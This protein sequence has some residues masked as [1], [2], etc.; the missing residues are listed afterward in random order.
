MKRIKISVI[1]SIYNKG[2]FLKEALDSLIGQTFKDF[3]IICVNDASEDAYTNAILKEYQKREER[4]TAIWLTENVGPGKAKNIGFEQARGEYI[5]FL[6]ADDIFHSNMLGEMYKEITAN[7]ADV[8]FCGLEWFYM[9]D[10]TKMYTVKHYPYVYA[11]HRNEEDAASKIY[12]STCDKLCRRT[13]LKENQICFQELPSQDDLLYS[14]MVCFKTIKQCKC[15]ELFIKY[16]TQIS[17]QISANENLMNFFKAMEEVLCR[18]G[19][20]K[21]LKK[22]VV[23]TIIIWGT[24]T[25]SREKEKK[26]KNNYYIFIQEIL[27]KNKE[28]SFECKIYNF[29]FTHILVNDYDEEWLA[30]MWDYDVQLAVY[31]DELKE[32]L[33]YDN[34][35]VLWGTG[36]RGTAFQKFCKKKN[37]HLT[38]VADSKNEMVGNNTLYGYPIIHTDEVAEK[39]DI[40][41]ACNHT[42]FGFLKE[43]MGNLPIIDLQQYCSLR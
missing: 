36:N 26:R 29:Y 19:N 7:E 40:I 32:K 8:C 30:H 14:C 41:V 9:E 23:L 39:A 37:W 16:R 18:V 21:W 3:E 43:K 4:M 12:L 20:E 27:K 22:Q 5:I 24:Y 13:F 6:D 15:D 31:E 17:N 25:L 38:A 42:V 10:G 28:I 33:G 35:I 34:R 2:I 1:M 11:D